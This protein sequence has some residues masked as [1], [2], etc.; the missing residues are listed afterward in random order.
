MI[1]NNPY[2]RLVLGLSLLALSGLASAQKI[3][4]TLIFS[5]SLTT[6]TND[7]VT[8]TVFT[9][10]NPVT[11]DAANG[12]FTG[13][14]SVTYQDLDTN[15]PAGLLWSSTRFTFELTSL[16]QD[17]V[18]GTAPNRIRGIGGIGTLKDTDNILENTEGTWTFSTQENSV[19][20]KFS[21][22]ASTVPEPLTVSLLG[23]GLVGVGLAR[24]AKS[25]Y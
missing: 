11:V 3:T 14:N 25:A 5:G 7:V 20:G 10:N 9:F 12:D 24:R 23:L 6:D 1:P 8:A 4:G 17:T 18:T 13:I 21:F 22:S 2:L 15:G 19:N 16:V